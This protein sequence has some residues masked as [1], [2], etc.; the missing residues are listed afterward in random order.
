MGGAAE[1]KLSGYRHERSMRDYAKVS[2]RSPAGPA[3]GILSAMIDGFPGL[4]I[5]GKEAP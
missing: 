5:L 4:Q 2:S 3:G 1:R